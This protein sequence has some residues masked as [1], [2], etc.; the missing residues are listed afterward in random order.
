MNILITG[1]RS[2]GKT[3]LMKALANKYS[4]L[5]HDVVEIE[6]MEN[7]IP[8]NESRTF[9]MQRM[10][11]RRGAAYKHCLV[12][13]QNMHYLNVKPYGIKEFFDYYIHTIGNPPPVR[14]NK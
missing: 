2:S 6:A 5:G 8:N 13:I 11:K 3:F 7:D 12:V 9:F 10:Y 14:G 4:E 1:Y